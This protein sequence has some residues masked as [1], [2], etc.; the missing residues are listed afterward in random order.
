MLKRGPILNRQSR[1]LVLKLH[2]YFERE[3]ANGGPLLEVTKVQERVAQALGMG[4]R[5]VGKILKEKYGPSGS[6]D[7]VLHT[8][9]KRKK[10]L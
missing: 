5:T 7:N 8:P 1:G 4:R 10:N 3:S 9:K 6:E 2:E